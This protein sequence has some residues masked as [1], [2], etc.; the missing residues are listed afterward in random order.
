MRTG[1]P[2]RA[3]PLGSLVQWLWSVCYR[4]RPPVRTKRNAG[5]SWF[6]CIA[7]LAQNIFYGRKA[8]AQTCHYVQYTISNICISLLYSSRLVPYPGPKGNYFMKICSSTELRMVGEQQDKKISRWKRWRIEFWKTCRNTRNCGSQYSSGLDYFS[9][10][11]SPLLANIFS[12]QFANN[13]IV[14]IIYFPFVK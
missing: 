6:V 3:P 10:L 13:V 7:L 11:C 8:S 2:S 5:A 9:L 12:H 1:L 14:N 4:R